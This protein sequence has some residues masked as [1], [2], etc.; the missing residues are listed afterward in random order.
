MLKAKHLQVFFYLSLD[1]RAVIVA[2]CTVSARICF[3]SVTHLFESRHFNSTDSKTFSHFTDFIQFSAEPNFRKTYSDKITLLKLNLPRTQPY[4]T[5]ILKKSEK[6]LIVKNLQ[7]K[8]ILFL[9]INSLQSELFEIFFKIF[10]EY[11]RVRRV[12][13]F[14]RVNR[15]ASC[16]RKVILD[17]SEYLTNSVQIV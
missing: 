13:Y 2:M 17:V 9:I 8:I 16:F 14:N 4:Q 7:S 15:S 11:G 1:L 12:W 5:K 3:T 6:V 10:V